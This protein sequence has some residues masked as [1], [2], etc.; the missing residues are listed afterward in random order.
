MLRDYVVQQLKLNYLLYDLEAM[1]IWVIVIDDDRIVTRH[2][3]PSFYTWNNSRFTIQKSFF[4]Y[5][6]N[7]FG[8]DDTFMDKS[9]TFF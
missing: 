4:F 7:E 9:F 1:R 5:S 3:G 6:S 8:T 2:D